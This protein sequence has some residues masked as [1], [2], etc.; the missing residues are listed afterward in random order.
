ML[1]IER[2][3]GRDEM[4]SLALCGSSA[5]SKASL[6]SGL[7]P[8]GDCWTIEKDARLVSDAIMV[9][10][11]FIFWE[12]DVQRDFVLPGGKLYV[13]GAEK[14]LPNIKRLT[15]AARQGKVFLVSHGDFHAP[16]DAE[17]RIFPPHC[18]KGTP[19]SELVPEAITEHV[20]RVP[21]ESD[22]KLPND[23]SPYQQILL[24]KQ[25]LSIFE[26]RHADAL[27]QKLG[28]HAEFVVFGV[29][30]E[31]CVSFAVK[32]LLERGRRVAVVQDAIETL[33]REEG[34]KAVQDFQ[35]LGARLIT[36]DQALAAVSG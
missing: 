14:L 27:V 5:T 8:C 36:T 10:R 7:K 19:G 25:T 15:D 20:V 11:D 34:D 21:N 22:A 12:V 2:L 16:N 33:Q 9:S 28:N 1:A 30:T 4:G 18:V 3:D 32:G 23:L 29:V 26:S 13:P 31:Y 17:F 24:E 35:R 6:I